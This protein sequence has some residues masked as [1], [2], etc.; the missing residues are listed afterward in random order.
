MAIKITQE[1][2]DKAYESA[3]RGLTQEQIAAQLG[4]SE[5][6]LYN[7]LK[8]NLEFLEAIK[9]GQ[10]SGIQQVANA[11][12]ETAIDGN[13]TAQIFYLK[14]RAGWADKQEL[15]VDAKVDFENKT[16]KE[17]QEKLRSGN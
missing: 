13:T 7:K 5:A 2:L 1:I 14:N 12:F 8:S 6:T 4:M 15:K 11:M 16:L 10:A 9:S 17:I 3:S